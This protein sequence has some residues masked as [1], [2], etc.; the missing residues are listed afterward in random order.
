MSKKVLII[1]ITIFI[2]LI[3]IMGAGFF[4][5]MNKMSA[6]D[7]NSEKGSEEVAEAE[8]AVDTIGPIYSLDTFIV[9]LAD[10]DGRRYLR[11]AVELE[12]SSKELAQELE[13]RLP[14][15]R[16]SILMI[17]PTKSVEDV[18][19]FEGKTTLRD[20]IITKLNTFLVDGDIINLYFTEFVIQ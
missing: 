18:H 3:M 16:D 15:I 2:M 9:N 8:D 4:V 12:L 10:P 5:I 6:L 20:E 19:S 14:Q 7:P 1:V 17:V 11:F 13:K